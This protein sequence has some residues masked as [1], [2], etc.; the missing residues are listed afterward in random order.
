[1]Q[2]EVLEAVITV[3]AYFNEKQKHATYRAAELAGFK[4]LRLLSEPS[5]AAIA[6]GI[7]ENTE[8]SSIMIY[9]FGGGTLDISILCFAD[10]HFM[11][12]AKGGNMWLGGDDIDQT[13]YDYICEKLQ[14]E[15]EISS[16]ELFLKSLNQGDRLRLQGE[17]TR[18]AEKTKLE[19]SQKNESLIEINSAAKSPKGQRI[20]TDLLI[21]KKI[22]NELIQPFVDESNRL[23]RQLLESVHFTPEMISQVLMVGGSSSIPAFQ[24]SLKNLFGTEKVKIHDRP[25]LAIA[26]GA[27]ILAKKLTGQPTAAN[28]LGEIMYRS[29][30]DYYLKLA[31]GSQ[32]LLVEKQT[33]LPVIIKKTLKYE[34]ST[35]LLGHFCFSNKVNEKYESIG[36]LWL[37]HMP[38]EY[39][40]CPEAK[41][42]EIDFT[43]TVSEDELVKVDVKIIASPEIHLSKT[44]SRGNTDELLFEKLHES[45]VTFNE[46]YKDDEELRSKCFNYLYFSASI[47]QMITKD[48][49]PLVENS[50]ASG[51]RLLQEKLDKI[52]GKIDLAKDLSV[53]INQ[54]D[55]DGFIWY[56][57][58][59]LFEI[60]KLFGSRFEKA[61]LLQYKELLANAY[62]NITQIN[63]QKEIE[64]ALDRALDFIKENEHQNYMY[65]SS[66]AGYGSSHDGDAEFSGV[67]TGVR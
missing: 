60:E 31:D 21:S 35:Q 37:S 44:L 28:A 54:E 16:M 2:D 9:D 25:M 11:E 14:K 36:D 66:L 10:A 24:D 46:K 48:I 55:D 18:A 39:G 17:I 64:N 67:R 52:I 45:I 26:E 29:A 50:K 51:S 61:N 32:M 15:F 65:Y 58:K 23:V 47:G 56:K 5:A 59:E 42:A 63:S 49:T 41:P 1:M 53:N 7:D 20:Q 22:F 62:E 13:L 43:F 4:V 40:Y 19:L 8:A 12:Q 3:P 33:P 38:E 57:Y 6:Y 34:T 30:H 27:A